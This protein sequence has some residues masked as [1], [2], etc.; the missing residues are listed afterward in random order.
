MAFS[1]LQTGVANRIQ[2][3][4][5]RLPG[6]AVDGFIRQAI[7]DRY[8]KDRP[9]IIVSDVAGAGT[10]DLPLP[11]GPNAEQ[12]ED[13]FS[14]IRTIE[15]PMGEL[16]P[17]YIDDQ[18]WRLYRTPTGLVVRM[19]LVTPSEDEQARFE[20][21]SRHL[22]DASTLPGADLDAV[23]D[24]AAAL[25]MVAIASGYIQLTDSSLQSDSVNYRTK[26]QE[27][28]AQAKQ[29]RTQYFAHVGVEADASG[30]ESS[31]AALAIGDFNNIMGPGVDR[32]IHGRRTR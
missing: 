3:A 15:Y 20:W 14:V 28:L 7:A 10:S 32:F 17:V 24:Y 29:F 5:G 27:A 30:T 2:D 26:S 23:C 13:G 9:R 4:A 12:F 25:C 6:D 19:M 22:A 16:P 21:T 31:G 8:S 18:D 1:D 11:T